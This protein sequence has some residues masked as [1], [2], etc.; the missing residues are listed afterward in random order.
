MNLEK[1]LPY[2]DQY[3]WSREEKTQVLYAMWRLTEAQADKAFS[4]NSVQL[5]CGQ[6]KNIA[7]EF[8]SYTV[9]S[10]GTNNVHTS[11]KAAND[12]VAQAKGGQHVAK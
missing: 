4:L 10:K 2:L 9:D 8:S 12:D 1:Y 5:S 6:N 3:E 7:S 11:I